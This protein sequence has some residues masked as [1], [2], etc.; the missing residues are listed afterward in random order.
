M[1][2][3]LSFKVEIDGLEEKI[4]RQIEIN[5]L[6]SIADLA[7]TI[8][9]SFNSLAKHSYVIKHSDDIYNCTSDNVDNKKYL[10]AE[11]CMLRKINFLDKKLYMEYDMDNLVK[12]NITYLGSRKLENG[13]SRK[14]P[15]IA[16][17]Q[18]QG[19]IE[20]VGIEKLKEIVYN[21]DRD[22]ISDYM[23]TSTYNLGIQSVYDYREYDID[24]DNILL[25]T[26]VQKIKYRYEKYINKR[27]ELNA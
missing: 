15:F 2:S 18:G 5:D 17:G 26:K 3:I 20:D 9:A 8:L 22:G 27:H 7:Y 11:T 14:Y 21:T 13:R 19:M 6:K 12:F 4:W 1:G 23:Y 16:D 24:N 25:K 10:R